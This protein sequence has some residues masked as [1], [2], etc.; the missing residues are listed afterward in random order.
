MAQID[1]AAF[2]AAMQRLNDGI[3]SIGGIMAE[4][5]QK[6][7]Q[8]VLLPYSD[9]IKILGGAS[10][11]VV[12]SGATPSVLK[13]SRVPLGVDSPD[14]REWSDAVGQMTLRQFQH[15]IEQRISGVVSPWDALALYANRP[16]TSDAD[17]ETIRRS[18]RRLAEWFEAGEPYSVAVPRVLAKNAALPG[19]PHASGFLP[20]E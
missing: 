19:D 5:Q 8:A 3:A 2:D 6:V 14:V 16:E 4:A 13:A 15:A 12:N 18:R 9:A 1:Q 11:G 10:P 7:L 20:G 17:A